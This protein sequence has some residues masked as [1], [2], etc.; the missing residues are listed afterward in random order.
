MSIPSAPQPRLVQPARTT[1]LHE[2]VEDACVEPFGQ[3]ISG[4]SRLFHVEGDSDGLGPAA[5]LAVHFPAGDLLV[6][7]VLVDPQQ[8][9][10]EGQGWAKWG[11]AVR[12]ACSLYTPGTLPAGTCWTPPSPIRVQRT[13]AVRRP[14]MWDV[15]LPQLNH[16]KGLLASVPSLI[17]R[18]LCHLLAASVSPCLT[19]GRC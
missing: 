10:R 19:W 2:K 8:V 17:K 18:W 1:H 4:V 13:A 3:G 12:A 11:K 15:V 16:S 7:A 6:E 14:G 5:P 9:G